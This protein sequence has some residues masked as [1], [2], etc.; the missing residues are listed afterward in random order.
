MLMEK[1]HSVPATLC[2]QI[3]SWLPGVHQACVLPLA[4]DLVIRSPHYKWC[5][6]SSHLCIASC[7]TLRA[8]KLQHLSALPSNHLTGLW[9][10]SIGKHAACTLEGVMAIALPCELLSVLHANALQVNV[11]VLNL[12]AAGTQSGRQKYIRVPDV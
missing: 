5:S 2:F 1:K 3:F 4:E 7:H 10:L 12:Q 9:K 8:L 11:L 6:K